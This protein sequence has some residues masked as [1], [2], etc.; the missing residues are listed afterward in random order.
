MINV[1]RHLAQAIKNE[2]GRALI[3]GG[4]VRDRIMGRESKDIDVE[5]FN[6]GI[7]RLP[8]ILAQFGHVESVGAQFPVYK[9]IPH[10]APVGEA[11]DVAI[12]RR[13]SKSG[14][15]HKG[16]VV[17]GDPSMTLEEA[18][19]RRDFTINAIMFD[20]L[21]DEY[22]DLV[23]GYDDIQHGILRMVNPNTFADDSLRVYRAV[24]FAARFNFDLHIATSA[25]CAGIDLSD[26]PAERVWGEFEKLLLADRP[27][28]GL[29]LMYRLDIIHRYYP[30]LAALIM[31]EQDPEWHPEGYV[32]EHT[33]MVVD[34]AARINTDLPRPER[35]ALVLAALC[36]DLGKPSTT[37]LENGRWRAPGHEEAGVAPAT[38]L[39]D[40]LNVHTI[41]GFDV[42]GTVLA[43]T[44]DHL[45]PMLFH[46]AKKVGDG[47]FRRL[48][49]K[50]NLE[51]LARMASADALG[52]GGA[53]NDDAAQWFRA[54]AKDLGV[55]NKPVDPI[56][57][58]RHLIE[59]GMKPG[60][61]MGKLLALVYELQMDGLIETLDDAKA[62][63]AAR[64]AL[65]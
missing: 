11:I 40:Q 62:A 1:V 9:L 58:G 7:D 17:E 48:A 46:S 61:E 26:L 38:V 27:S 4:W 18:V 51:H 14:T 52:R 23:G 19:N 13:E 37:V 15:G 5:V 22:V 60:P 45:K 42:R 10:G 8:S 6:V 56:L 30:E 39:L 28:V 65:L 29:W 63:A 41:D 33:L 64:I 49:R 50:V 44:E 21:T 54:R 2:G 47:A 3:V 43:L 31:C 55:T 12:P 57:L 25:T 35:V 20:P 53:V 16:F 24:Q 34:Q 36:H 59:L 32:W